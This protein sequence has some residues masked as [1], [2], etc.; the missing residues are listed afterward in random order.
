MSDA[1]KKELSE[2]R[3]LWILHRDGSLQMVWGDEALL[4]RR[5]DVRGGRY[6]R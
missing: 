5:S 4:A 6:G 1:V 3:I 2:L